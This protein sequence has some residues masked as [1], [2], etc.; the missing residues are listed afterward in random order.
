MCLVNF[1]W[2]PGILDFIGCWMFCVFCCEYS[3][4]LFWGSVDW[5]GSSLVLRGYLFGGCRP[6]LWNWLSHAAWGSA[7]CVLSCVLCVRSISHPGWWKDTGT[8]WAPG[9]SLWPFQVVACCLLSPRK[10][11]EGSGVAGPDCVCPPGLWPAYCRH[12]LGTL[13]LTCATWPESTIWKLLFCVFCLLC[14]IVSSARVN[15][16][17]KQKSS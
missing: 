14:L 17:Q 5:L 4:A 16:G 15:L 13:E 11:P 7:L 12:E 10:T 2:M 8:Q 3:W 6:A 1:G 9:C